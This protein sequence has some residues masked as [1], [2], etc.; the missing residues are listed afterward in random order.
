LFISSGTGN[1]PFVAMM[2][3]TDLRMATTVP[4][5]RCNTCSWCR[6]ANISSW[7]AARERAHVRRVRRKDNRTDMI[8][9]KRIH[10]RPQH[11]QRQQERTF[12]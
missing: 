7:S 12:Q 9:Q 3:T 6:N 1:A 2:E 8:A 5:L 4:A 10:R 11:Q